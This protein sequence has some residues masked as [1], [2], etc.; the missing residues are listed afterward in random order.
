MAMLI[1]CIPHWAHAALLL[2]V[3]LLQCGSHDHCLFG[4]CILLGGGSIAGCCVVVGVQVLSY[5][6]PI[7]VNV[8]VGQLHVGVLTDFLTSTAVQ[9]QQQPAT[10]TC[11]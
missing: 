8:L 1:V 2:I 7:V 9:C 11:W 5:S 3:R 4:L 10:C 6:Y